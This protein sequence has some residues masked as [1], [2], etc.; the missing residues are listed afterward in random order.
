MSI[1]EKISFKKQSF[2]LREDVIL[3]A[4]QRLLASKGFDLMTMDDVA[5][6]AGLAKP[7][8]YKHFKSKED[9]VGEVMTRLVDEAMDFLDAQSPALSPTQK[10]RG[11]L[12]WALRVRFSGGLPFLPSTSSHVRE[13]LV[14]NLGYVTKVL[15]LNGRLTK[16]V[17]KAQELGELRSDLPVDVILYSF[18]ARTCDP[19]ADYLKLYSKMDD[20]AIVSHMLEVCFGGIATGPAR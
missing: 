13:M 5:A 15:R 8:L 19:A 9:L 7:S 16:L 2:K 20:E 11:L 14:R 4:T 10:L 12:E 1:F 3:D 17:E 6:E 18:Y